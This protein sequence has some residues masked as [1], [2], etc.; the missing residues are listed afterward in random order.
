MKVA[1]CVFKNKNIEEN[2]QK[3]LESI[4]I[5]SENKANMICFCECA[6][7][8]YV[9]VYPE[10]RHNDIFL[11]THSNYIKQIL[12]AAIDYKIYI[13]FGFYEET[14]NG[15]YNSALLIN[16]NG[17]IILH[18]H[19]LA[20]SWGNGSKI[21]FSKKNYLIGK[22]INTVDT[23]HGK[24]AIL[25]CDDYNNLDMLE[26]NVD[27]IFFPFAWSMSNPFAKFKDLKFETPNPYINHFKN[28]D[29]ISSWL[30]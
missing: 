10:Y 2:M 5:A 27:Y 11:D 17:E 22:G 7:T 15:Y 28:I 30:Q 25:I 1:L 6:I 16:D 20:D 18:H 19:K 14:I 8:G 21:L 9:H 13:S 23:K 4:H 12:K 3:M 26:G 24:F 29:S